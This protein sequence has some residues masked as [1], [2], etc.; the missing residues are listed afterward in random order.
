MNKVCNQCGEEFKHRSSR[1]KFCSTDCYHKSKIKIKKKT[2]LVCG[3]IFKPVHDNNAKYCSNK[4][5]G[6][7]SRTVKDKICETCGKSYRISTTKK[8]YEK[9]KYCSRYCKEN[10]KQK[11]EKTRNCLECKNEYQ[12]YRIND[13]GFCSRECK[14]KKIIRDKTRQCAW[15]GK[16]FYR[17]NKNII[18]CSKECMYK[19]LAS[20][21]PT[22]I[23]K[24]LY[25]FLDK[26]GVEYN[27]QYYLKFT[28]PDA[29]LPKYNLCIYADGIYWHSEKINKGRDARQNR[30]LN[31]LGYNVMRLAEQKDRGL[32]LEPLK[33][34]LTS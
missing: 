4:C 8:S 15:C 28:I 12:V 13:E 5:N 20:R 6:I 22:S 26:T 1:V 19:G 32:D 14:N 7:A 30:K 31:R 25:E 3:K 29:Y 16:D 27:K 17:K 21:E 18:H 34:L 2:C 9:S 23:E 11:Q 33:Q 24:I 10:N